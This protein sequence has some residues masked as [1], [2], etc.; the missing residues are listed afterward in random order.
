MD[1][2]WK[3]ITPSDFAWER[4]GLAFVKERLPDHEPYRVWANFEFI[5]TDGSINEVDMLVLTPKGCFLVEIKSWPGEIFGDA[6]TWI[7]THEGRRRIYDNP[8]LLTDRK[9]KKL[10][11]L[12]KA[13]RAAKRSQDQRVPFI[14]AQVFLSA[15]GVKNH[16][17]GPARMHVYTREGII[18]ALMDLGEN[19]H[20]RINA[21]T[22]RMLTQAMEQAGIKES[23][24]LRKVG[25]YRLGTLLDEADHFQ[26]WLGEHTEL[27][28][29]QR[30]IR[31]YLTYGKPEAEAKRLQRAASLE[32]QLLEGVD[33]P[34]ILR[35]REYQQHD[36]GPALVYDYDP[37][38]ERLDHY[39][40]HNSPDGPLDV[41]IALELIREIAEAVRY[42][43]DKRLYHR[44]LSPQ[45]VYVK[46]DD[47]GRPRIKIGNWSFAARL[48][49]S[50]TTQLSLL[51]RMSR[52][53][54]E[55]AGPYVALEAHSDAQAD[56]T[57]LDVFSLGAIA[58]LLFTG[59]KPAQSDLELQ[60]KLRLNNGL[61]VT[62]ELNGASEELQELI[63]FATH[64]DVA[65]RIDSVTS[66]LEYLTLAEEAF[67]RPDNLRLGNPVEAR[68]GDLLEEGWLVRKRLGRGASAVTFLVAR[69][70]QE[71]VL[72]LAADCG[73]NTRIEDEGQI[74][75]QLRHQA[76][77]G[78]H[79]AVHMGGH[80][81]ILIDHA[82]EGTLARRLRTEGPVQLELLERFGD[83]LLSAL[84]HLEE[85]GVAHRDIKPENLGLVK[86]G[87]QLHLVLFDFSL[88][89]TPQDNF[90]A[91][92]P[93]Y[94]DP[95]LRDPGRRRWDDYAERFACGLTLYEMVTA[96]LPSWSNGNG[97]PV[98][99]EGELAIDSS[100]FDP[101]LR[102]SM[103]AFFR[104]ALTRDIKQRFDNAEEMLRAWRQ[105]FMEV[106]REPVQ[107]AADTPVQRFSPQEAA[108][109][110]QVGL[111]EL[112][113]Q[114]LD[115]LGRLNINRVDELI[116]LPRNELVRM[117][118]VGTNTRREL[119]D[120]IEVLRE[121][122]A[123]RPEELGPKPARRGSPGEGAE[124]V[125]VAHPER[126]GTDSI[127]ALF[128]QVFPARMS[129]PVRKGFLNEFLGRPDQPR[130]P[131][132]HDNVF[133]PGLAALGGEVGL[134]R[135]QAQALL[136][137]L[138]AQWSKTA[139]VTALR[140][141]VVELLDD[142]GGVMT[143]TELAEALLLRRG[144]TQ[145]SPW[146][147]RW[148]QA[149]LR[150]AVETELTRQESR[151]TLRRSGKRV[152]IADN[153][154][155]RGEEWADYAD[156]LGGVADECAEQQ[157][158]MPPIR[159]L[160]KVRVVAPPQGF[161]YLSNHRLLRLSAAASQ[162]AALSSRAEFYPR[163][164]AARRALQLGQGALLG[165]KDLTV[166]EVQARIQ[167]R[168]PEAEPLPGRP[169]L[170]G[171]IRELDIGFQWDGDY[172]RNGDRGAY[173]LPT[174]SGQSLVGAST[175]LTTGSLHG[176]EPDALSGGDEKTF[177]RQVETAIEER[178]FLAL[179]VRPHHMAQAAEGLVA[180][181][182]FRA[183][184]FDEL[185]LRHI[186]R[187]CEAMA[188]PPQ[189]EVVLRADGAEANSRDWQNLQRLVNRALPGMTR[190]VLEGGEPVL[191]TDTG[192][193]GRYKLVHSW[194]QPLRDRLLADPQMPALVLLIASDGQHAGATIDDTPIPAGAG[195]REFARVPRGWVS[196]GS[197][198]EA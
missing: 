107:P 185:L 131:L 151:W 9:A 111:L 161:Q 35:A 14:E 1:K 54:Q 37:Q 171:W 32:F 114:A 93:A 148:A 69:E 144:S 143:A 39:L 72:K 113:P 184:S 28:G 158:L 134:E 139:S 105:V 125:V 182:G 120:L 115:T 36:H 181:Y 52:M 123:T 87:S 29:V 38:A 147:E 155:G 58:Y 170:D 152:L 108:L 61:Q 33:H 162:N 11:S 83:D 116:R 100:I 97:M 8:R 34:G 55:E 18:P 124:A 89:R 80:A 187:V 137:K 173:R 156:A 168:Y 44:A 43:H 159:A 45:S 48:F 192:L 133:W 103:T 71:W 178:R 129:D 153:R 165:A 135:E 104:K 62:D 75:Q 198:R 84:C 176:S 24:R 5:A 40:L 149:V 195:A 145:E 78:C 26:E 164:M 13:Q 49:E 64:P 141:E 196:A 179:G 92:T 121:R 22:A 163:R 51:S 30:R 174:R 65:F 197:A 6:G 183:I 90:T 94:L 17:F 95:F 106:G 102:E 15:Q 169:E 23:A 53:I 57:Y 77:V 74:L 101:A 160:E 27:S 82:G 136:D 98:L 128:R 193:L 73:Q 47:Q 25:L 190:E 138:I 166:R 186:H 194:L 175:H 118:G 122:F 117:T 79:Q 76:I 31:I 188:R 42:A 99:I 60:D 20:R 81:G 91:G 154:D 12:L 130:S 146:R 41:N 150:V 132:G 177:R 140:H 70:Q 191:L 172:K 50:D 2:L 142:S 88:S 19:G 10:S 180:V 85:K 86:R 157:P 63:R 110:T 67:T 109:D 189:W 59:R 167:G 3:Q 127:D 21:P 16:L 56:G 46:E 66:F 68:P 112:S 119:S 126:A 4:E 7:W 96:T